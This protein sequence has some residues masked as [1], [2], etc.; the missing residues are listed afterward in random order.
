MK[1]NIHL[2]LS[3]F[4]LELEFFQKKV[5]VKL[6]THNLYSVTYFLIVPFMR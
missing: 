5:V 2:H 3:R 6:T 4:F 1:T